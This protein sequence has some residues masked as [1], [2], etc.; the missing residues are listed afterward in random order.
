MKSALVFLG[1]C[2][3][4]VVHAQITEAVSE[5]IAKERSS[6]AAQR[7]AVQREFDV[8]S[9]ACWQR[10]AVND[11]ISKARRVRRTQLNRFGKQSSH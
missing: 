4:N 6:L 5:S 9:E 3:L 10:F 8:Q 7:S 11:C 1:A 2:L